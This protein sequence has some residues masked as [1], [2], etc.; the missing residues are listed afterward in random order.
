MPSGRR[1]A[2]LSR[3]HPSRWHPVLQ[4][5]TRA[6]IQRC[7]PKIGWKGRSKSWG[8]QQVLV[9][10]IFLGWKEYFC[11]RGIFLVGCAATAA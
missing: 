5:Q 4:Q 1:G 10:R 11:A 3:Y 2:A 7:P 9:G 8:G 6:Q